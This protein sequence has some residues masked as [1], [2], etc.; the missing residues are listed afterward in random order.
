MYSWVATKK[1]LSLITGHTH[2]PV[3]ASLTHLERIYIKLNKAKKEKNADDLAVLNAELHKLIKEGDKTPRFGKYK[4]GYFNSGCCC[5]SDGDMTGIEIEN[6][7][8][9]LIKWSYHRNAI[10]ERI[11]LEEMKLSELLDLNLFNG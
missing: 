4:P 1:N 2:Q 10:P 5:F 6:G 3:F 9:R 7:F 8:I 11:L